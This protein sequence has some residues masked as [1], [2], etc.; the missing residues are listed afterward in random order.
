MFEG[1]RRVDFFEVH[2]ENYMGAGGPMHHLLHRIRSDYS[3]SLHGVGL[4]IGGAAPLDRDHLRRLQRLIDIY[5]PF[6]FS[7]HLAWSSHEGVFLNDLLP[8]PYN[9][10][11]LGHVCAHIDQVQD[12]L[13][14]RMLLENPATYVTFATST[15]PEIDFLRAVVARTGCG[16]LLDVNNVYVSSVNLG[17]EASAYIDAFPVEHV[18]ELHLAGFAEDQDSEG[19]RLLIDDHG[20]AVSEAVWTL[21]R[22]VLARHCTA[23]TLIEW[24]NE[25]PDFAALAAEAGRARRLRLAVSPTMAAA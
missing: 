12:V 24:D 25:V 1:D 11:T 15:M 19:A 18:G 8:L 6:L 9:E 20:R 16:L 17:F 7:E 5:E 4:S 3:V 13:T 10:S 21:Y 14:T 2:A 22:R 23:P